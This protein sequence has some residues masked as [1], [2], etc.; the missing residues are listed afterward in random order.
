[1]FLAA[2]ALIHASDSKYINDMGGM[3]DKMKLTFAA[4]LIAA[5]SLSG[6]PPFSGFWSK[7]AILGAAWGAGQYALF[8]VGALTAGLTVF[9]SFRMVGLVFLGDSSKRLAEVEGQGHHV[10]EPGPI[11]WVPYS[12]LAAVTV[13]IGLVALAG[14]AIPALNVDAALQSA[15]QSYILYL[16]PGAVLAAP[17]GALDLAPVSLTL[18]I[19]AVGFL[20]ALALYLARWSSPSRFVGQTGLMHGLYTF[21]YNR[22]YINAIYYKVFVDAPIAASRWLSEKFDYTGLFRIND[23]GS[24]FGVYLSSAG[25][26]V[27]VNIVDGTANGFSTVGQALSR[28][29]RKLQTGIV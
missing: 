12:I 24:V 7:D 23:A 29:F 4:V 10:H 6:I 27:D 8:A 20:A 2:G 14:E 26:W 18:G 5:A 28:A 16:Y 25:N 1:L 9:Y 13:L 17:S 3:R 11:M 19:V 15:A 22:W 21:L